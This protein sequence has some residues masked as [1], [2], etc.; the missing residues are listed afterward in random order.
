MNKQLEQTTNYIG[1]SHYDW[2]ASFYGEMDDIS[3]YSRVLSQEEIMGEYNRI[4]GRLNDKYARGDR[5][6]LELDRYISAGTV[7]PTVGKS[8]STIEWECSEPGVI[9]ADMSINAPAAGEPDKSV[10]FTATITN[11]SA[12][13]KKRFEAV[14]LAEPAFKDIDDYPM[15]AVKLTDGY[16]ENA[17]DKMRDYLMDID[18]GR[19][20]AGFREMAGIAH[21]EEPYGGWESSLIAGHSV[22]HYITAVAQEYAYSEAGEPDAEVLERLN[23]LVDALSEAQIKE[24]G[25]VQGQPVKAGYLFA[26]A[27]KN[28]Y[29][30][31]P[32]Y[33]EQQFDNIEAG[34]GNIIE[35][36]WVPWY[37]MHKILAG[38]TDAYK[39]SGNE[40]ALDAADLLGTWVYNRVK[41]YD[42]TILDDGTTM[43][44]RV[45]NV[46]Y[47]GMNDALY[48]LYK[49][50]GDPNHAKA[51]HMF[52][53]ISLFD[54]IYNGNDVLSG[55]HANTTIP[56]IIG[57]LNRYRTYGQKGDTLLADSPDD[58]HDIDYYLTAAEN[59]WDMVVNDHSYITGGN[60]E[61]EHFRDPHTEDAYRNNVNCETC[62]TYNML[63]LSR[64]LYKIT[65][66]RKY[67][68]YYENTL[69]NAIVSSQNP[70]TGM[71]MYFQ[72]MASGY[73]K[74]YSDPYKNFWCCTGSGMES[75]TKLSDSIYYRRDNTIIVD[76][77]ISSELTDEA[78]GVR[79]IQ[80]SDII[81]GE[82]ASFEVTETG[83]V[84]EN[85]WSVTAEQSESEGSVTVSGTVS[86]NSGSGR[87]AAVYAAAYENGILKS[88]GKT[89]LDTADGGTYSFSSELAASDGDEIKV[90][91][92][93]EEMTPLVP[94]L[95]PK[96]AVSLALRIPDWT[97]DAPVIKVNGTETEYVQSAGYVTVQGLSG[98]DTVEVSFPKEVRAY[99]LDDSDTAVAFKY[100]P[101]V[102]SAS[103]GVISVENNE[104]NTESHG[105]GVR[106]PIRM[107]GLNEYIVIEPDY[108][109]RGE[110]LENIDENV[111]KTDGKLEFRLN[112]TDRD[113]LVFTPHYSKY[114]EYYGIY[115]YLMTTGDEDEAEILGDKQAGREAN[116]TIDSI[117]P[118]HDQQENGHGWKGE[119]TVF[120]EGVGSV[121][122]YREIKN[123]GYADYQM[124]VDTSVT[125]YV[126][127]TYVGADAGKKMSIYAG[128]VKIADVTA[129]DEDETVKYAIPAEA[130]ESAYTAGAGAAAIEGK[131]A[132]HIVFRADCGTDA[133]KLN[134]TVR[135]VK[136]YGTNASLASLAF[137]GAELSPAFEPDITEY[138][139]R[140]DGSGTV[141]MRAEP[142]EEY[143]LVYVNG[144]LINDSLAR[145]VEVSSEPLVITVTA[146]DHT[147]E[148]TY[149]INFE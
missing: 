18:L 90:Y 130:L 80:N 73:F 101:V 126:A 61:N 100:G 76:Q 16:L 104:Q 34:K 35:E 95:T 137:E 46:E 50:T 45:L 135:I 66:E 14:I 132:M 111:V 56:K 51:A 23:A 87:K 48:E 88:V 97:A 85:G 144:K 142:A 22:G 11:G 36:A 79:I 28:W 123:G 63:K 72:P 58:T 15:T 7:L 21:T 119:N 98:G 136:D 149:T 26:A 71:T 118:G 93:D 81:N 106:K 83:G 128:D 121:L 25:T 143:G 138:T 59:F 65:G 42:T 113:D 3:I 55:K 53:E 8:E 77:Y 107:D 89:E 44:Q 78:N 129:G 105:M 12:S 86:N 67:A 110:W 37:T 29:D 13:Y 99:G 62:N 1:K 39:L 124:A 54:E 91:L 5:D 84:S 92:W 60:S 40:K 141:T 147:T 19:Y 103:L 31:T 122:N 64:E 108:G 41:D 145:A 109:T 117:E 2:D 94:A 57:A 125:N 134:G 131:T 114:S 116:V 102:L 96:N 127:V 47:G 6:A 69:L 74:V 139:L 140:A 43:Q 146:E 30:F 120:A 24:D 112:N 133:P 70:Q 9:A 49:I 38:L 52:D 10:S 82:T 115:W 4:A 75:M 17:N 33:G 32:M 20:V 68:D 27:A 148:K